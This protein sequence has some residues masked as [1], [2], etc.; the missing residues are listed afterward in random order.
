MI[1]GNKLLKAFAA[2][3]KAALAESS[4]PIS[5][6]TDNIHNIWEDWESKIE[7]EPSIPLPSQC[8]VDPRQGYFEFHKETNKTE[9][10]TV[11]SGES[12]LMEI[13]ALIDRSKAGSASRWKTQSD[14]RQA[15]EYLYSASKARGRRDERTGGESV[16]ITPYTLAEAVATGV[17][18]NLEN[19]YLRAGLS[20]LVD[21]LLRIVPDEANGLCDVDFE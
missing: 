16:D 12:V 11:G 5:L 6:D 14:I 7:E 2:G 9:Y 15:S 3:A 19:K 17:S 18:L 8:Q 13:Q 20:L 4:K 1:D 21:T 10:K